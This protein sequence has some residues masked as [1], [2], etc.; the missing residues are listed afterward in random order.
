MSE[1]NLDK[2]LHVMTDMEIIKRL[3]SYAIPFIPKFFITLVLML[4]SVLAGLLEPYLTGKSI[5]IINDDVVDLQVLYMYLGVFIA[6]ILV[7]N[8]LN[9]AQTIILQKTGQSIIYNIREEI[10]THLEYHDVAYLNSTP[11]GAL[12]TR[13]TNDTNTLSEMYTNVIVSVF[14][15]VIMVVL[16]IVAM[17]FINVHLTLLI[18]IV[19]PFIIFFSFL[20]RRFSRKAYRA[21]RAN[22]SK[23][24]AFLAEH[25]SGM[26]IIQIFNQEEDKFNEFDERNSRLKRSYYRQIFV[27]GLYRPTM[28]LLYMIALVIVFY[29]GGISVIEGIIT[30]GVL[31]TFQSYIGRFFEPIQQ[32]AEQFNTLQSAFA[33]A[34][35]LFGILDNKP[36]ISDTENAIDIENMKG[37]IEFRNVWFSYI[38]EDWIL[39]DVSFKVK[40]KES[41]AFIGAT[42]AGKTTILRLITRNYDIQK[43]QILIDGIDIMDISKNTLRKFIGVML[44]D[45]FMFSGTIE[46][47]I[48]LRDDTISD[49]KM[50]QACKYVNANSFIDKLKSKYQEPVKERGNN[51]STGQRQL[52]S[53]ART[54]VHDPKVMILDEATSN[55][56]T[57][58][59]Q[60]IQD[61]LEKM[62]SI[63][64]MLIV[65][66]RLSTIQH[67][68]NIIVL[69]KGEIIEQGKHQELLKN[70]GHYYSLYKLQ[71]QEK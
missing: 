68:D 52:L 39:R 6:A 34:E 35:R 67:V 11:T 17:L 40:A 47:N 3:L 71:Y 26:K 31:I 15:N 24:N 13:V 28:Y 22:L 62:M 23:V 65:A 43:G 49:E 69:S 38:K 42:G 1:E 61:S 54:I 58:T 56:D 59:E 64:T 33:S 53:F 32:L 14:R 37:E 21:V 41:V 70:K 44:Q 9:Y 57:E 25:L 18:L 5:D 2:R 50:M 66:H 30:I 45:V 16:I 36:M 4:F 20:F 12:V 60:L 29:Y 51:F 55:I 63:G 48:K 19:V 8:I 7:G 27:F 10:F 46:S